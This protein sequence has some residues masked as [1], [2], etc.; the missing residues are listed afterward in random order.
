M[1][2][3]FPGDGLTLIA[4]DPR[5]HGYVDITNSS[6]EVDTR[7]YLGPGEES[8]RFVLVRGKGRLAKVR[9]LLGAVL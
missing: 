4:R 5:R 9:A 6:G 3:V 8:V 7:V 2:H 1:T